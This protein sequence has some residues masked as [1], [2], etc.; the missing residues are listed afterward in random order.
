MVG[1]SQALVFTLLTD[2]FTGLMGDHDEEGEH[3]H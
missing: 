2:V 3:G 1:A